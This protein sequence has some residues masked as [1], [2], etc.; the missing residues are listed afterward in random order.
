MI[1]VI[2]GSCPPRPPGCR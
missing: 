2:G 1:D